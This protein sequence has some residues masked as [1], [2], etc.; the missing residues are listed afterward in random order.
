[1]A[2]IL[3][4]K[5]EKEHESRVCI[6]MNLSGGAEVVVLKTAYVARYQFITIILLVI[7]TDRFLDFKSMKFYFTSSCT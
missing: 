2:V 5:R 1:M 6:E 4:Q 3:L 7:K